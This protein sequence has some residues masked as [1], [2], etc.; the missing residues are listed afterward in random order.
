MK[1]IFNKSVQDV[2]DG[3]TFRVDFRKRSVKI[4]GREIILN[5]VCGGDRC[6]GHPD[7]PLEE[8]ERLYRQYR[9]SVPTERSETKRKRYF[10][11]L[12]E[13]ELTDEDM[14]YGES[15]DVAQLRLELTVLMMIL[16][17]SLVWDDFAKDK[18][19]WKSEKEPTLILLKEWFE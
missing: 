1:E 5:S 11:P 17:G 3:A 10:I 16:D 2:Y 18:W 13:E 6:P 7:N 4:N 15:R 19:F 14:L 12:P 9:H 8:I